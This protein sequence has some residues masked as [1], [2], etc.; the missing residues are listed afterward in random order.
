MRYL[1][2]VECFAGAPGAPLVGVSDLEIGW[3]DGGVPMLYAVAGQGGGLVVLSAGGALTLQAQFGLPSGSGLSGPMRLEMVEAGSGGTMLALHGCPGVGITGYD[4]T[5]SGG[6]GGHRVL[7]GS[8]STGACAALEVVHLPGSGG[9]G[10]AY[11]AIAG[12]TGL[13][14][15]QV[16]A[17]G[18]MHSPSAAL[19]GTPLDTTPIPAL[20]QATVGASTF[21]LALSAVDNRLACYRVGSTGALTLTGTVGA[22]GGLGIAVPQA[23]E[24]VSAGGAVYA[25]VAASGTSSIS[26][27]RVAGAGDLTV[28]DQVN[29]TL[30]TRFQ[31]L[32]TFETV[33]VGDRV[34]ILAGGADDGLS[35]LTLLPNGRLLHLDTIAA[36]SDAPLCNTGALAAAWMN[37]GLDIF[38]AGEGAGGVT[39]LRA[40]LGA[41][42]P[43]KLG[44]AGNDALSGDARGDLLDGGAGNDTLSG[45]AGDDILI[46]GAGNDRLIGGTGADIFVLALDGARDVIADFQPGIDRLDL[47]ALGPVYSLAAFT[48]QVTATGLILTWGVEVLEIVTASGTPLQPAQLAGTDVFN[49]WHVPVDQ[50]L[51]GHAEV[52]TPGADTLSGGAGA[53]EL[54]GLGGNDRLSGQGGDDTIWGG[55]GNDTLDGGAGNDDLYGG[56]GNDTLYG[57]DGDDMMHG[58][59]G[60]DAL[61]GGTGIDTVTYE[62]YRGNMRLGAHIIDL[63]FPETNT[64][65]AAG[66]IYS[67]ISNVIGSDSRELLRGD[68]AANILS[69]EGNVDF[70]PGRGGDDTI[71]G[72][73]S[74]DF[75]VGG[76]GGDHLDGGADFD[77]AWYLYAATAIRADLQLPGQNTGE[78]AGD[79]YV[80]IECLAGTKFSDTLLGDQ[81]GNLLI[82]GGG[83]DRLYGRGGDDTLNGGA[84]YDTMSGEAGD[85]HFY[86]GNAVD[87]FIF[88]MGHD[89]IE[90]YGVNGYL[91]IIAI[92]ASRTAGLTSGA[93]I[94]AAFADVVGSNTVFDF[95]GGHTLMVRGMTDLALLAEHT[96]LG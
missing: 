46:D 24:T 63:M 93:Q 65:D 70:I 26:V 43:V 60:I 76:T 6:L 5:V 67:G 20:A 39:R 56:D 40:D 27:V 44:G 33:T 36:C 8:A 54:T 9:N 14:L 64:G 1:S 49:L 32:T 2:P 58:G 83:E 13:T 72:G 79:T 30:E 17:D 73:A 50:V 77:Q 74:N 10:L 41:L 91:D 62:G 53:D 55:D 89:V 85:D 22:D 57:G 48:A 87:T 37:N 68:N 90:D 92:D 71:Y 95:G 88:L 78:A 12:S 34:L 18:T 82:G 66:D 3:S 4:V 96:M 21:L 23:I 52:G 28:T 16:D 61:F 80:D 19:A 86:G 59:A 94:V 7:T 75:L 11:T 47:S 45:G 81:Y 35:L 51:P 29:D 15:W 31:S 42:A 25:L 84:G 69:G 38:A